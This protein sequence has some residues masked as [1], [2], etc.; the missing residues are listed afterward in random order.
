VLVAAE[1]GGSWLDDV[2]ADDDDVAI[3]AITVAELQVGVELADRRRRET[4]SVF[5]DGLLEML[6]IEPYDLAVADSHARLLAHARRA[7]T[8]RGAHDLVI[9]AT[10]VARGRT[11]VT[12]DGRGFEG[13]PELEVRLF[14]PGK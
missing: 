3:A 8:A 9:A 11:V 1:R 2:I 10:A 4:R 13:L 14:A 12:S 6:A 7:G 5:V